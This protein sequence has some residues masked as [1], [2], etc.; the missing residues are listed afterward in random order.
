LPSVHVLDADPD[1]GS[2]L[3]ESRLAEARSRLVASVHVARRGPW[4][5]GR[6]LYADRAH[7][8]LLILDGVVA[9]EV[10]LDD[11]VSAELLGPGDLIR[12]WQS[13]GPARLVQ[14]E[15]RWTVLQQAKI[16][17]LGPGFGAALGAY[18]E[19]NA[20]LIDRVTE[21]AHRLGLAQAISQLNGVDRRVLALFWHLAE[22][23]G[24]ITGDG[25]VIP[26]S[27]PHRIVAQ[28]VGARRPTVSTLRRH[29]AAPR[30][31]GRPAD[32]PG[33]PVR[34]AAHAARAPARRP[35]MSATR[36][37]RS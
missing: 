31:S 17:V 8:G 4:G 37:A 33:G 34:P 21:R 30:R 19:V 26:L 1:L 5:D 6:A 7:L 18:P 2:L 10:L 15:A 20:M 36:P 13:H 11:N 35:G 32:R 24:R 14:A 9:R 25:V 29:V 22:R 16:A 27:L 23:W 28:L 12:P 3:P